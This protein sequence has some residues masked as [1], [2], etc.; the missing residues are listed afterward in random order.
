MID[1]AG[2]DGNHDIVGHKFAAIHDVLDTQTC[3]RAFRDGF[4]QHVAG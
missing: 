4:A 3:S 2:D 1:S